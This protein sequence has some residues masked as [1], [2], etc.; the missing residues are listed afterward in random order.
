MRE[1]VPEVCTL[2]NRSSVECWRPF[3]SIIYSMLLLNACGHLD[4]FKDHRV[5]VYNSFTDTFLQINTQRIFYFFF[6]LNKTVQSF[7]FHLT[8]VNCLYTHGLMEKCEY[9]LA[10]VVDKFQTSLYICIYMVNDTDEK[11]S[12]NKIKLYRGIR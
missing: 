5:F 3:V 7:A 8:H 11:K 4:R 9:C 1:L 2:V 10:L 12:H 6:F